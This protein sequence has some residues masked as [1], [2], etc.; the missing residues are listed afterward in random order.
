[1]KNLK[2]LILIM[3]G[4]FLISQ[5]KP[6]GTPISK[7]PFLKIEKG[8]GVGGRIY[9]F[10]S[11]KLKNGYAEIKF[12]EDLSGVIENIQDAIVMVT[13][14]GAWSGIYVEK[15]DTKGFIVKS[16]AG[17]VNANFDWMV[18]VKVKNQKKDRF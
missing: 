2:I 8:K 6:E 4:I 15:I 1:M 16:G 13:P 12:E 3:M 5:T 7:S 17:D 14:R 9:L 18:V 10:G 11:S